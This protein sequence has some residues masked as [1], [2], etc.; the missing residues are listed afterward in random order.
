MN[1]EVLKLSALL[2]DVEHCCVFSFPSP[3]IDIKSVQYS[4]QIQGKGR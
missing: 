4:T 1:A 2:I 3:G